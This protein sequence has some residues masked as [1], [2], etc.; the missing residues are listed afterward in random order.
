MDTATFFCTCPRNTADLLAG[1]A[2]EAGAGEISEYTN[3]IKFTG[4]L[5]IGYRLCLWSRTGSQ[6]LVEIGN[7]QVSSAD[8]LYA[9]ALRIDWSAH[10]D[11]KTTFAVYATVT[12]ESPVN[13]NFAVLRVKDA[14]ADY[15]R[16]KTGGQRPSVSTESPDVAVSVH[17]GGTE[18]TFYIDLSGES[19]HRRGYRREAG[20]APLKENLAAVILLR[21]GWPE[22][23]KS[24][25]ALVDPMC[26]SGTIPI[27]GALIAADIAPGLTRLRFGFE[28][29]KQHD[30]GLW[31]PMVKEAL[32]RRADGMNR[33]PR[34]TGYDQDRHA[35]ARAVAAAERLGL[36]GAVHFERRELNSVLPPGSHKGLVAVNPPY[37][38][39]LQDKDTLLPLY[40]NLGRVLK[41]SFPGWKAAILS[42]ERELSMA[43]TLR[44]SKVNTL[45]NG[46]IPCVLAQFDIYAD[47]P[48][49]GAGVRDIYLE[50]FGNR[51]EKNYG[52]LSKWAAKE[53]ISCYRVYDADMPEFSAAIDFYENS[54]VHVQEYAPPKTVEP[55]SARAR[56]QVILETIPKVLN[57]RREHV[58]VKTRERQDDNRQ[59]EHIGNTG[60]FNEIHEGGLSFLVNFTDYLDT[61][62]FL[63][64]RITRALIRDLAGDRTFLN[65]FSY[66][67]TATVYALQ[68]GAK[69]TVSVDNSNTYTSWAADNLRLNGMFDET[70]LREEAR[71]Y[72]SRSG[73]RFDLIFIDPPTFS[74]SKRF[75]QTFQIQRDHVELITM[76]LAKLTPSGIILFST[77]FRKFKLDYPALQGLQVE[78][79]TKPTIPEDFKRTPKMHQL[80]KISR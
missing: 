11:V 20:P 37:G 71:E 80:W 32:A 16:D 33:L 23:A 51:L 59:Y 42:G 1:E 12:K 2:R 78:D 41:T 57:V 29:W 69:S 7:Y 31:K 77:N 27:E 4:A 52:H 50:Q 40:R 76:A 15:F 13:R 61:G 67:A 62:I 65:L 19:L 55:R 22:I 45:Y 18:A 79:L 21:A 17:I 60:V 24:G 3:G 48:Q 58:Y 6:I 73:P 66:T 36:S 14:I 44:A 35:V 54:W 70:L 47:E 74:R 5:E 72:L 43:T 10:M 63:D 28:T 46:D 38:V 75:R 34:I 39:R 9:G 8:D 25:G 49:R 64:H 56:L 26:G 53:G 68:G 30:A